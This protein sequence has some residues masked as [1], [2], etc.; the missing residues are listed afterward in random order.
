MQR[1]ALRRALLGLI[2][3]VFT[4]IA[5]A[6]LVWPHRM[7]EGLGYTLDNVDALNEFR[8]IYVGLWLATAVLLFVAMRRVDEAILGDLGALL[9][10]GQVVGRMV[11]VVLDGP[12]TARLWPI[13]GLETAGAVALFLTRPAGSRRG[14]GRP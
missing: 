1:S 13:F 5:L 8:A 2:A 7:A 9:I 10:L 3:L 11:S 12:P 4:A 14:L 6:S